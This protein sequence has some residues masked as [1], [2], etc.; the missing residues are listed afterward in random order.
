MTGRGD[1]ILGTIR[2]TFFN[3]GVREARMHTDHERVLEVLQGEGA[4]RNGTYQQRRKFWPIRPRTVRPLT[5]GETVFDTLKG[6][7][8]R[9][10]NLT[11]A[12]A[13]WISHETWQMA[14]RRTALH[15]SGRSSATEVR[16]ERREYLQSLQVNR[17]K[18]VQESG[19]YIESIMEAGKVQEA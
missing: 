16:Q 4:Q 7:V 10:Q 5:E 15:R 11:T 12:Q 1:Y 14:D 9:A 6:E 2:H 17:R 3:V 18:I 19:M 13:S 8:D